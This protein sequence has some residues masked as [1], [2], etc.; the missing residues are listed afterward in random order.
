MA[1]WTPR[2]EYSFPYWQHCTCCHITDG[3]IKGIPVWLLWPPGSLH[4]VSPGLHL[5][6]LSPL[7][8]LIYVLLL[9][10]TLNS[11]YN[12]FSILSPSSKS[13]SL[14]VVMGTPDTCTKV[15]FF[16]Y[17]N[18]SAKASFISKC[19][20][21]CLMR[22]SFAILSSY[23][24]SLLSLIVL[25]FWNFQLYELDLIIISQRYPKLSNIFF[26]LFFRLGNFLFICYQLH[27]LFPFVIS[28]LPL[29]LLSEFW[30]QQLYFTVL[31]PPLGSCIFLYFIIRAALK[32]LFPNSNK[33]S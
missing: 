31:K 24:F 25:S 10:W 4:L 29:R 16:S 23:I 8:I 14:K 18:V 22:H 12:S 13:L 20:C 32:L 1:F 27:W 3:K 5:M 9:Q 21:V 11:K 19:V 26:F 7:P 30:F 28:I 6:C 17:L 2:T 33:W 15:W